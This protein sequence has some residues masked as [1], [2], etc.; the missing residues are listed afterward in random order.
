MT[1]QQPGMVPYLGYE[2]ANKALEFLSRAFGFK[3]TQ[4]FR[5]DAGAVIHAEMTFNGGVIMLG[6]GPDKQRVEADRHGPADR[7]VY[8]VVED[9]D[10][11]FAQAQTAGA[12]IVYGP[13]DTEFGTRRY[14]VMD[15]EGYE[16]S[17][18][19]Y[20]PKTS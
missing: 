16:W 2:D 20:A 10:A 7:G 18:G 15:P 1:D 17:F 9:V 4:V 12:T 3:E 5:D 11:H 6:T 14:R 19:T 13:Q 8:C